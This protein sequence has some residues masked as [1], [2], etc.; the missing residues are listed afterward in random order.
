MKMLG[1]AL[2]T[3]G[4]GLVGSLTAR[5][6]FEMPSEKSFYSILE[7]LQNDDV[8]DRLI[9]MKQPSEQLD[10]TEVKEASEGSDDAEVKETSEG[11]D[12]IE[13]KEASKGSDDA[14]V[15]ETSEG[16]D[17][18]EVKETSSELDKV[19]VKPASELDDMEL[20]HIKVEQSNEKIVSSFEEGGHDAPV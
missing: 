1:L 16:T 18:V 6:L 2:A 5:K 20:S 13:V 14:E 7:L 19:V 11:T 12:D 15:K 10:N 4:F 3:T 8:V 17:D 9:H